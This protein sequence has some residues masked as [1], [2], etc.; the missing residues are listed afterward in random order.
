MMC[1]MFENMTRY[2]VM[3]HVNILTAEVVSKIFNHDKV[4]PFIITGLKSWQGV[5]LKTR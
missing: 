2:C 4:G 3:F 1:Q 5:S